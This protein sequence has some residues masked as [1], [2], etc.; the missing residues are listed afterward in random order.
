MATKRVILTGISGS[1][2]C[3][4]FAHIMHN[5]DWHVIGISSFR[6]KGW[7]DKVSQ[8]FI[9]HPEW[10]ERLTMITH[11]LI[12]PM[13]ELTKK[14]IG[15]VDYIINMAALSDVEA[16]IQDPVTFIQNNTWLS[17]NMLE[18]AR[19]CKPE[20]F[21]QISTDE[22][23]GP[24]IEG[25][26]FEE[27]SPILPSNPYAA[28]KACQEAIA[29]AYWRTYDV[30]VVITNTVNNFGEMQQHNKYPVIVQKKVAAGEKVSVHGKEGLIG[31]RFYLHSRNF[32]DAILFILKNLPPYKH[33]ANAVDR[34]DR[35]NIT[36][37]E[38][39]NNLE[40]AQ[41]IAKLMGQELKY[42][43]SDHHTT[44][45][46]HDP[47]YGLSGKK[48]EELGWTPPLNFE[49]SLKKVI[50]WQTANPDWIK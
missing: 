10:Q 35:Y 21:I 27:W 33:V 43:M 41:I 45:P 25:E 44:R 18:Y 38:R 4:F 37:K 32:A 16:S 28:S 34:P 40:F 15:H 30:P 50:E 39:I 29:I 26:Q 48:M 1:I 17:L 46:G 5:T 36:G 13:S 2:G 11:D 49:E 6:H 3:H 9:D 47:H 14:R 12:G 24:S 42:E 8:A 20:S 7:S 22:T 19:E 31:S 23:Y